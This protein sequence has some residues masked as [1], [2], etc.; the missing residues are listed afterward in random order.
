MAEPDSARSLAQAHLKQEMGEGTDPKPKRPR[1]LS[2][3]NLTEEPA[4]FQ[5]RTLGGSL[6]GFDEH[7]AKLLSR[8]RQ[9]R[10]LL[11]ILIWWT[12][13]RWVILDGHHR[14]AAYHLHAEATGATAKAYK[15]PVKACPAETLED[16]EKAAH[17]DN[18]MVRNPVQDVDRKELGWKLTAEDPTRSYGFI[19]ERTGFS[20]STARD[21]RKVY[22]KLREKR[23]STTRIKA[24]SWA[25]ARKGAAD[26]KPDINT[27]DAADFFVLIER[28]ADFLQAGMK[29]QFGR[30][31]ARKPDA[32]AFMLTRYYPEFTFKMIESDFWEFAGEEEDRDGA[33]EDDEDGD[34]EA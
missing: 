33:E 20:P 6:D 15:V 23:W 3:D 4:I 7:V 2:L 1:T 9:K 12:G 10:P 18:A 32:F 16:A 13:Q 30:K 25:A 21:M 22:H 11:P 26:E 19:S 28:E 34:E 17:E 5:M 27:M 29:A 31:W 8:L 24:A 14:L